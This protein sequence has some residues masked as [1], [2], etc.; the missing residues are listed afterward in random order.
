MS[1]AQACLSSKARLDL[2]KGALEDILFADD[3]LV[4]GSCG[5]HVE[6]YMAAIEKQGHEY[7]LQVHWGKTQLVTACIQQ[8]LTCPNGQPLPNSQSMIYLG[9][10]I[11]SN[12]KF[13]S[14][15]ARKLGIAAADFRALNV[16]WKHAAL[17]KARKLAIF[18][19]V[20]VSRLRYSTASAWL[21]KGDLRRLDGFH[22]RCLRTILGVKPSF[23]SR[24]TNG[25]V[26]SLAARRPLSCAIRHSQLKLLGDVL[27]SPDKTMLKEVTFQSNT[28]FPMTDAWVRKVGRPKHEWTTQLLSLMQ[29]MAGTAE[30]WREAISSHDQWMEL[31]GKACV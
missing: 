29:K 14:E 30:K 31:V 25:K 4:I 20:V 26:R 7:G 15:V 28:V 9:S 22:V 2:A 8:Q 16:V 3:T 19:A 1:D 10:T 27:F 18:D 24:V 13:S 5:S 11:H 21:S 23:I 6:E 17:A 12:G